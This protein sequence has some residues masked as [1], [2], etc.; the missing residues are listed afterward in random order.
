MYIGLGFIISHVLCW[1]HQS[2][3]FVP[4]RFNIVKPFVGHIICR[5]PLWFVTP[6]CQRQFWSALYQINGSSV[7]SV[8][9]LLWPVLGLH[10]S[11]V[12]GFLEWPRPLELGPSFQWYLS[13]QCVASGHLI[14]FAFSIIGIVVRLEG[15][16]KEGAVGE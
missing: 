13:L 6:S 9:C 8:L 16:E 1:L 10:S 14:L 7:C 4:L 2:Q 3:L 15:V 11:V 12:I 5:S